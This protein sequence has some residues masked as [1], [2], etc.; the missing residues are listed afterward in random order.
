MANWVKLSGSPVN[1]VDMDHVTAVSFKSTEAHLHLAN[2]IALP[3]LQ[4]DTNLLRLD[5]QADIDA[6]KQWLD[7]NAK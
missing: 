6:I 1:A 3:P 2:P 7:D 5:H 4:S